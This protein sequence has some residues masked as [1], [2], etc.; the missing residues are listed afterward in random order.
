MCGFELADCRH[1]PYAVDQRHD[2]LPDAVAQHVFSDDIRIGKRE[3][4]RG[5]QRFDIHVQHG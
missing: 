3:Q 5:L 4:K 2:G 1:I